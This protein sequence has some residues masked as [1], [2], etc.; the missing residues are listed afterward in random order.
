MLRQQRTGCQEKDN[1]DCWICSLRQQ[2]MHDKGG[3]LPPP[4]A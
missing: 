1:D 2:D 3:V 4:I